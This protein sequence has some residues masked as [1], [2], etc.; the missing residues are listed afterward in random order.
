MFDAL[1][2]RAEDIRSILLSGKNPFKLK[3]NFIGVACQI[4]LMRPNVT[5]ALL[6]LTF[7]DHFKTSAKI[8]D[9][10]ARFALQILDHVS[11][12]VET[13]TGYAL[14]RPDQDK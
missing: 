13:E 12:I 9:T 10:N 8:A 4:F 3:G 6:A 5:R 11:A 2:M 7:E 14:K 1:N